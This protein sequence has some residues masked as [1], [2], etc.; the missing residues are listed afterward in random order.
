MKTNNSL[1]F[2]VFC[3][4][5]VLATSCA[6]LGDS[7]TQLGNGYLYRVD[8]S[9]RWIGSDHTMKD[10]I[11]SN[12]L[13]Y[14]FDDHFIIV[15]QE[16]SFKGYEEL[17][18]EDLLYRYSFVI[19]NKDTSKYDVSEKRFLKSH[20]WTDSSIH[21][22]VLRK[23]LPNNQSTVLDLTAIADS[24]IKNDFFYRKAFLN[25]QNYWIVKKDTYSVLG[26]FTKAEYIK[27]KN[28]LQIDK[29]L[30]LKRE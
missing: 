22:R 4:I 8:G 21:K 3:V 1:P 29:A 12:V 20:L 28:D 23:I 11:Y 24:I 6:N 27:V 14:A 17:L 25:K 18:S 26:P 7:S 13:D 16:P 30:K 9:N 5:L 2:L 15:L 19:D 10:R